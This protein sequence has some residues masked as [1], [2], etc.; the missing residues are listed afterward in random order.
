ME[1]QLLFVRLRYVLRFQFS[2]TVLAPM[3]SGRVLSEAPRGAGFRRNHFFSRML[4]CVGA[5]MCLYI[6]C[7]MYGGLGTPWEQTIHPH[8]CPCPIFTPFELTC[9]ATFVL[10]LKHVKKSSTDMILGKI[11]RRPQ[12]FLKNQKYRLFSPLMKEMGADSN[13]P[14]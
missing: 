3:L 2:R 1:Q 11:V 7:I 9:F 6:T 10:L 5:W 13:C 4:W 12:D 14:F 8:T